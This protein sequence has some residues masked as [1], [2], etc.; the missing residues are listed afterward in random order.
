[1]LIFD[2]SIQSAREY[3]TEP[4]IFFGAATEQNTKL[5]LGSWFFL[6]ICEINAKWFKTSK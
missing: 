6:S 3:T 1:M 5:D 4:H 2:K